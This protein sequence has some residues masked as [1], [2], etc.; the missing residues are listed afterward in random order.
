MPTVVV[1][2]NIPEL[3]LVARGKVRDVYAVEDDKLLMVAVGVHGESAGCGR[4]RS[5]RRS[6]ALQGA[7][8]PRGQHKWRGTLR[9]RG[10]D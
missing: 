9:N 5:G 6:I 3:E 2:T 8:G 7:R 10:Y 4:R 1:E